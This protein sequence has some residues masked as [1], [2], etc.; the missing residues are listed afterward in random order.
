MA[1]FATFKRLNDKG[2]V[3]HRFSGGE[4]ESGVWNSRLSRIDNGAVG[5]V[6]ITVGSA[7][8]YK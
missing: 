4:H 7:R 2:W 3:A 5:D 6:D 8:T 1:T